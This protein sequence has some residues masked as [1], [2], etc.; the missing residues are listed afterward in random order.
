MSYSISVASIHDI[1][2]VSELVNQYACSHVLADVD[3]L[4]LSQA[5]K[6]QLRQLH[7]DF[8]TPVHRNMIQP[9]LNDSLL[10]CCKHMIEILFSQWQTAFHV[11]HNRG[12]SRHSFKSR[13]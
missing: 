4:Y 2:L 12:R 10:K 8:W 6:E 5:L 11:E 9:N 3:Y 7:I 1:Q 13:L